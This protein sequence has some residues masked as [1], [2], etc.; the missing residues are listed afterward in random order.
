MD[1]D[2]SGSIDYME[3][4]QG[5]RMGKVP[6]MPEEGKRQGLPDIARHVIPCSQFKGKTRV[7]NAC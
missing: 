6:Y 4:T 1:K 2:K 7:Q 5:L 3:F